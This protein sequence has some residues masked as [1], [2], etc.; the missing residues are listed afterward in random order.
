LAI[1]YAMH[2][3]SYQYRHLSSTKQQTPS[4]LCCFCLGGAE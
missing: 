2:N 4:K 3:I 1:G